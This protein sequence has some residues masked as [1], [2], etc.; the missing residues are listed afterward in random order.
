MFDIR[1]MPESDNIQSPESGTGRP[2]SGRNIAGF[3]PSRPD[4][5]GS[6]Y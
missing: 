1:S 5:D 4:L 3:R 6:G 2:N